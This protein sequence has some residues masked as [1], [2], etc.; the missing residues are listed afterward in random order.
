MG[1]QGLV[2][3][4][5]L[6]DINFGLPED[7]A[8]HRK[9][10]AYYEILGVN[11]NA[12]SDEIKKAVRAVTLRYHP[13]RITDKSENAQKAATKRQKLINDIAEIL[14]DDAGDLGAE[15]SRRAQYDRIS[16]YGEFFGSPHIEREGERTSSICET[17]L[18]LLE[19]KKRNVERDYKSKA[20][21]PEFY[22]L[23]K[24]FYDA[25]ERDDSSAA[26][27]LEKSL[28]EKIAEKQGV[29]V[30]DL[31]RA[32]EEARPQMEKRA[33]AQEE[34]NNKFLSGLA[35]ELAAARAYRGENIG[36]QRIYEIWY[37]GQEGADNTVVFGVK[38]ANSFRIVGHKETD[39][40]VTLGL[41]GNCQL[42][43]MRKVHFKAERANVTVRDA[44][45][46]GLVQIVH[47][48]VTIDYEG[49]SYGTVIRV[50]APNVSVPHHDFV[51]S[52]DLYIPAAF[53][54]QGWEQRQPALDIAVMDGS[55]TLQL[56]DSEVQKSIIPYFS[57]KNIKDPY[58]INTREN[59]S[60]IHKYNFLKKRY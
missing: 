37:N 47:G 22:A 60:T 38:G 34:K 10:W 28:L 20:E 8:P 7:L 29:T 46:E 17:L 4:D 40:I 55:V 33:R 21:D 25:I 24:Q 52:G 43:G 19:M 42:L 2:L 14:L 41:V 31:K 45:V 50:R 13:D 11:T 49:S 15:W 36:Q 48:N 54:A 18:D 6:G 9:P 1:Q 16:Q 59:Y 5:R 27:A 12:S 53:A 44:Y 26:K 57:S 39:T 32:E 58:L 23:Q 51:Q 30:E 3:V 56:R 35:D